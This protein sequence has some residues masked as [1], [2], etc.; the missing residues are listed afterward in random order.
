M[1]A[2]D[3]PVDLQGSRRGVH[4]AEISGRLYKMAEEVKNNLAEPADLDYV[5]KLGI[6]LL[7][8]AIGKAITFTDP[9]TGEEEVYRLW[10]G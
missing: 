6:T 2:L 9:S 10:R 8:S 7:N 3:Q 4:A 1:G 5:I